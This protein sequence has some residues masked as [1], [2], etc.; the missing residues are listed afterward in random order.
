MYWTCVKSNIQRW[1]FCY[2]PN[3]IVQFQKRSEY[4]DLFEIWF[5]LQ[6]IL[7]LFKNDSPNFHTWFSKD[8]SKLVF[9]ILFQKRRRH[10]F[11]MFSFWRRVKIITQHGAMLQQAAFNFSDLDLVTNPRDVLLFEP[12]A[13]TRQDKID[14]N[15]YRDAAL[16]KEMGGPVVIWWA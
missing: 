13:I 12:K 6:Y 2:S 11:F 5:K 9:D 7:G 8:C 15:H 1:S 3:H 10:F 14:N 4:N 16:S